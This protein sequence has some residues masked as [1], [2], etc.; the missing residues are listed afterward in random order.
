M[1]HTC[2]VNKRLFDLFENH[3]LFI[4]IYYI[5]RSAK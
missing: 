5:Y 1:L 3:L 4:N 2:M